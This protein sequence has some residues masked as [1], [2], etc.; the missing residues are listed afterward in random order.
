MSEPT[1]FIV[2]APKSGTT[3]LAAYLSKHPQIVFSDPKEP[4]Y[5]ATDLPG[6]RT[7]EHPDEYSALFEDDQKNGITQR[8]EGSVFYLYSQ[9]AIPAILAQLPRAQFIAMVRNPV[10]LAYSLHS[11]LLFSCDEDQDDFQT[12]W[13]LQE[14]RKAQKNIPDTCRA[15]TILQYRDVASTGHQIQRFKDLVPEAQRMVILFEDFVGDSGKI[16]REVLDFLH[17]PPDGR[18]EFPVVNPNEVYRFRG[19]RSFLAHPPKW[20]QNTT[21]FVQNQLGVKRLG[22]SDAISKFNSK[23]VK[24]KP[25]ASELRRKLYKE[26]EDDIALLEDALERDL[27]TW[28]T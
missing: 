15:S 11:Q 4:H 12:A 22:I 24:R 21:R 16:Y 17:L 2:G 20:L 10:D 6:L 8:G 13:S 1:F 19:L 3:A 27:S 18:T 28:R 9:E 26:F 5:F 23:K 14:T 7:V 25:L